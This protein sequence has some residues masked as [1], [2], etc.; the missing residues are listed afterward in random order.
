MH[1]IHMRLLDVLLPRCLFI[2]LNRD[3][4]ANV[5]SIVRVRWE[6]ASPEGGPLERY[7]VKPR[8]WAAFRDADFAGQA[9]AQVHYIRAN[10]RED[11]DFLG[12][13]RLLVVDYEKLTR[14]SRGTLDTVQ[15]FL[16][17]HGIP[18][19]IR[20]EIPGLLPTRGE[21]ALDAELE[22]Q[23]AEWRDRFWKGQ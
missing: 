4:S 3:R 14:D 18:A 9:C 13:D 19:R 5:R 8:E 15:Y 10:I 7:S 20:D 12:R 11:A 6:S 23:I 16:E 1:S 22:R 2:E 21:R 17:Y